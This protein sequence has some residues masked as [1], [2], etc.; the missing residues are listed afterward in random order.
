MISRGQLAV[1][2]RYA[3]RRVLEFRSSPVVVSVLFEIISY[4]ESQSFFE[5]GC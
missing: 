2:G 3:S 4:S 1:W 5:M